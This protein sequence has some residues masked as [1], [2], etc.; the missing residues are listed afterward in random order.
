MEG[1]LRV[2][3]GVAGLAGLA[4]GMILLLYREILTKSVFPT[5]SKKDAYRLL[6][7]IALLSWSVAICGIVAWAWSTALLHRSAAA[8]STAPLVV[9]GTV[10]D[11]T[12][13]LGIGNATIHIEGQDADYSSEDNGN[14]RIVLPVHPSDRVRVSVSRTGYL[15]TNQSVDPPVRDLI[16]QMRPK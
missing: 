7:S 3:G 5:L 6:R 2:V 4:V 8:D 14:F 10:V 12:T 9:A 15:E 1:I 11:Q 16:V 13:N